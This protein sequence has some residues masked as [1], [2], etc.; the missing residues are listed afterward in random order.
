MTENSGSGNRWEPVG[1]PP[2]E[3]PESAAVTQ[4]PEEPSPRRTRR[5]K[6]VLAGAAAALLLGGGAVGFTVAQVAGASADDQPGQQQLQ[7]PS[8]PAG[9]P[10]DHE[11]DHDHGGFDDDAPRSQDET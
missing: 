2:P 6:A 3:T 7:P 8:G 5:E 4:G 10:D 1:A 11:H 9:L